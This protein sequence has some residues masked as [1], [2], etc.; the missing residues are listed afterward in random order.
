MLFIGHEPKIS[1]E[2]NIRLPKIDLKATVTENVIKC[3]F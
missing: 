1:L 2:E 3:S